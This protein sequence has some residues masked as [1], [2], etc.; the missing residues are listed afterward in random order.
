MVL[1]QLPVPAITNESRLMGKGYRD[2]VNKH[3]FVSWCC[4]KIFLISNEGAD[5]DE[6]GRK[7]AAIR[8]RMKWSLLPD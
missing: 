6:T 3:L 7:I 1:G 4:L 8:L 2:R 5:L